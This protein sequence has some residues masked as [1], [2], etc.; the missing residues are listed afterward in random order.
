MKKDY[1]SPFRC[2]SLDNCTLK[3]F[4]KYGIYTQMIPVRVFT[5]VLTAHPVDLVR[6]LHI[7]VRTNIP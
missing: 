3:I 6:E 2:N 7:L 1:K 5:E 4:A